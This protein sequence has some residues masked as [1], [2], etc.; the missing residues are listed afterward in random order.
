[1]ERRPGSCC[2]L[3][4]GFT[5]CPACRHP[6]HLTPALLLPPRP[7][8]SVRSG[9]GASLKLFQAHTTGILSIAQAGSRTYTLA[10]DGSIKGWS[11][12][13]PHAAD[14]DAL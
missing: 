13:V 11:S 4:N 14:Q 12:A 3:S 10:A 9:D 1:M 6:P 2:R 8:C 5:S 7:A